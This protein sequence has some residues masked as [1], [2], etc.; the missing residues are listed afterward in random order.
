M[1]NGP[2]IITFA[3]FQQK[4]AR[5]SCELEDFQNVSLLESGSIGQGHAFGHTGHGH[6]HHQLQD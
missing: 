4:R 1:N 2:Q 3:L 6:A 5:K